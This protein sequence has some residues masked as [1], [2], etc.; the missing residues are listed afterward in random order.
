MK[1]TMYIVLTASVI[2]TGLMLVF[3]WYAMNGNQPWLAVF[4]LLLS[5]FMFLTAIGA[6]KAL[7]SR[8]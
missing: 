1:T 5:T 3:A 6:A 2:M 7:E 4:A 8:Q